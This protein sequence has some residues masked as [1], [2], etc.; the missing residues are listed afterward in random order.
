MK[1]EICEG[2]NCV[3]SEGNPVVIHS[4][5]CLCIACIEDRKRAYEISRLHTSKK[6]AKGVVETESK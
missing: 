5:L 6:Q 3:E 2:C 1:D 4:T